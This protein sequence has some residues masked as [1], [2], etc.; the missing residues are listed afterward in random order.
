MLPSAH[1][2]IKASGM[3][4]IY[5]IHGRYEKLIQNFNEKTLSKEIIWNS[6][7]KMGI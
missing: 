1:E 6:Y 3:K 2:E 7:E 4:G 5:N